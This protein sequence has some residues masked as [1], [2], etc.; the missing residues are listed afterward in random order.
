MLM[1]RIFTLLTVLACGLLT[2]A[3]NHV[4]ETFQFVDAEG[5]VVS[6]GTV[7]TV[8]EVD[9]ESGMMVVPLSV[10]NISGQKAAVSMLENIDNKPNGDWQTAPSTTA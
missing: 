1:K 8:S 9:P 3:Q 5:N 10:R 6:D 7:I 2:Y 4:D